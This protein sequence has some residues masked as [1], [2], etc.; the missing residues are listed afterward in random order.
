MC[1]FLT[2]VALAAAQPAFSLPPPRKRAPAPSCSSHWRLQAV[3][4]RQAVDITTK[5]GTVKLYD[6]ADPRELK[7]FAELLAGEAL[8][9]QRDFLRSTSRANTLVGFGTRTLN[10]TYSNPSSSTHHRSDTVDWSETCFERINSASG[11][12]PTRY[13][14]PN[15]SKSTTRSHFRDAENASTNASS[16]GSVDFTCPSGR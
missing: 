9:C 6:A 5:D 4:Q 2:C 16:L 3:D 8:A 10:S 1:K 11:A 13:L 7:A 14:P 12:R 15:T